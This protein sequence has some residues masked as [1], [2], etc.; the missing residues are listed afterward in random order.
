MHRPP[1]PPPT[2]TSTTTSFR[3]NIP[4]AVFACTG[5]FGNFVRTLVFSR[6]YPCPRPPSRTR[7][8]PFVFPSI[9]FRIDFFFFRFPKPR[10]SV[11]YTAYTVFFSPRRSPSKDIKW[12]HFY[13][14]LGTY[15]SCRASRLQLLSRHASRNLQLTICRTL[16][17]FLF[18]ISYKYRSWAGRFKNKMC[19]R[20][21]D[22]ILA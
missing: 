20:A 3:R 16:Y 22:F 12:V 5:Q 9:A 13:L 11:S 8:P 19:A 2:T 15:F 6:Q 7:Y 18:I 14:L 17:V 10:F 4:V 1:P 21:R